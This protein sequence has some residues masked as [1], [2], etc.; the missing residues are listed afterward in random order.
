MPSNKEIEITLTLKDAATKK[1][2]SFR[3]SVKEFSNAT[4]DSLAPILNLRQAWHKFG[5]ASAFVVAGLTAAVSQVNK[6]RE[7]VKQFDNIAIKMG[8][9]TETLSR[10]IYGFN[11]A[12]INARIGMG[13]FQAYGANIEKIVKGGSSGGL[14]IL[15]SIA[16]YWRAYNLR[17]NAEEEMR[18]VPSWSQALKEAERQK[19]AEIQTRKESEAYKKGIVAETIAKTKQLELSEYEYKRWLL[20]QEVKNYAN[21]GVGKINLSSYETVA[22]KRLEE[23]KTLELNKQQAVRL[24]SEGKTI[25]AFILEQKTA[26]QAYIRIWGP[27]SETTKAFID[28]QKVQLKEAKLAYYG[29]R[30]EAI[31]WRDL[32]KDSIQQTSQYFG[33]VLYSGIKNKFS[34]LKDVVASFGDTLLQAITQAAAAWVMTKSFGFLGLTFHKGGMVY[35]SSGIIR[36]HSGL[37]PDEVPLIAQTG[38]AVLSRR[39]VAAAG[40]PDVIRQFNTGRGGGNQTINYYNTIIAPPGTTKE[41]L[42]RMLINALNRNRPVKYAIKNR[43]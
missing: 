18:E 6:L 36:A 9:S 14:N 17:L 15:G 20:D 12:T 39:G 26:K 43:V 24:K 42:E 21:V 29:L 32:M 34:D 19:L 5:L 11:I 22:I 37:A 35:H 23:D 10:K 30:S 41:E 27:D 3:S 16:K 4:K 13:E 2:Q 1:I 25:Q 40:G 33:N 7:E 31:I 8:I 38:E 28:G